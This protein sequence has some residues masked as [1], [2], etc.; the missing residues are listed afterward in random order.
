LATLSN[1]YAQ[2]F[3]TKDEYNFCPTP[4]NFV[5]HEEVPELLADN[6]R[7]IDELLNDIGSVDIS[8]RKQS[9]LFFGSQSAGNLFKRSER[10]FKVLKD[11]LK[12][13]IQRYY[14]RHKNDSCEFIR[15]F[16]K[17][18]D[19]SSSW[20]IKMQSGG[21][22]TSHIHEEGW[23]SGAIYLL[24]PKKT[25]EG[26]E[27]AIELSTDG[28]EYPKLHD[29]FLKETILP[30]VGDVIFFPSS[31]FHRTIPF[32]SDEERICIAFDVRPEL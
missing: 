2:N 14:L 18:I 17:S 10:S 28:D 21:H 11:A 16:P 7:L 3:K 22:L 29:D 5:C 23:V 8:Q 30:K 27:G 1:H 25:Q 15:S 19:F 32:N 20:Y 6:G 31:V 24:I 4:L 9:R 26:N 13:V 12:K